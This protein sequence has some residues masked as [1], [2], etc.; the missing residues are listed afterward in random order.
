[1]IRRVLLLLATLVWI[2]AESASAIDHKNLDENRPL[3][4]E[5]AYPIAAGEIAIEVGGGLVVQ[6]DGKSHGVFP[7][8]ILYGA[9]PNLQLGAGTTLLT[10]PR[11]IDE[12]KSGD[13]KL[14]GLYNFNQETLTLP[15]LGFKLTVNLPTGVASSGVDVELK[16]LVTKSLGRLSF[17]LNAAYEFLNSSFADERAG[18]YQFVL[19]AS[20]PIGAPQYTRTTLIGDLFVEQA[21]Q[22]GRPDSFG[23][24]IGFRHQLTSRIVLDAGIGTE[25]AGPGDRL[26]FFFTT[27]FSIGF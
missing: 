5:D 13:L 2:G 6:R 21:S 14:S 9:L 22:R 20:Y 11:E 4:L 23:A 8:E 24:E 17:H 7:I 15:A 27:G 18:R 3:R 19:G 10:D 25:F 1:M 16:A 26:P 12:L